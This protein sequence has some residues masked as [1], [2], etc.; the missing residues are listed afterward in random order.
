M[1]KTILVV[2]LIVCSVFAL[3]AAKY[4]R[5]DGF[6]I[7]LSAGY[8]VSGGAFQVW[9]GRFSNCWYIRV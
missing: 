1:K 3:S 4:D 5:A 2:I 8:P 6:G 9:N 7:G